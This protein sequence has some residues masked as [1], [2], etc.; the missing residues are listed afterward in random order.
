MKELLI[1]LWKMLHLPTEWQ[2]AIMR[3]I[4]TQFLVG[5]TG[6]IF[7]DK[8]EILLFRHTYRKHAW[9]FPG[10]YVKA[11][12][13]PREGLEREIKEETGLTVNID[14]RYKIRTDR[15]TARLDVVYIGT[16]IG[17]EFTPSA[18]VTEAKF[19]PFDGLPHIYKNDLILLEKVMQFQKRNHISEL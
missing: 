18:E 13:H 1:K 14:S 15:A 19:F 17:G 11:K 9:G 10:G 5:V 8:D 2:L 7:N 4:Q 6:I 3:L 16:F 12:E